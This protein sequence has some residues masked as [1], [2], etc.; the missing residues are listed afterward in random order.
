MFDKYINDI[1]YIENNYIK[2]EIFL[3]G[4]YTIEPIYYK[5]NNNIVSEY[6]YNIGNVFY[7]K[8]VNN[9]NNLINL[10]INYTHNKIKNYYL[11]MIDINYFKYE[12]N[13]YTLYNDNVDIDYIEFKKHPYHVKILDYLKYDT[14]NSIILNSITNNPNIHNHCFKIINYYTLELQVFAFYI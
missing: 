12:D 13:L 10:M 11:E 9:I 8:N 14:E 7:N 4:Y 1:F 5:I 3:N 2:D 6:S